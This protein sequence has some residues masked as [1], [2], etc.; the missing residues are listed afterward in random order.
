MNVIILDI[1]GPQGRRLKYKEAFL[2]SALSF[3]VL[4]NKTIIRKV[5]V[6]LYWTHSDDFVKNKCI[7]KKE[8]L[9]IS[10]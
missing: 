3:Y 9:S 7:F 5:F 8:K 4:F 1:N 6:D 10:I 2:C